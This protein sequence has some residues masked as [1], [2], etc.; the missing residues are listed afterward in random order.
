MALFY[1]PSSSFLYSAAVYMSTWTRVYDFFKFTYNLYQVF[2]PTS[3]N[4][5]ETGWELHTG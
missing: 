2:G 3:A 1:F 5:N 4:K